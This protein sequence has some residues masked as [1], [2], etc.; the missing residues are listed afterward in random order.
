[1]KKIHRAAL[2]GMLI[3]CSTS[4]AQAACF[5]IQGKVHTTSLD[6]TTQLGT[7]ELNTEIGA[8]EGA[9]LGHITGANTSSIPVVTYLDHAVTFPGKAALFTH[10]DMGQLEPIP[11]DACTFKATEQLNIVGGA[12]KF[13][14]ASG[15]GTAVGTVNI[16]T[17]DNKFFISGQICTTP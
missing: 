17:G 12:G 3:A 10:N 15:S 1:M 14:G 16:C 2:A 8:L 6:Q 7:I 9:I 13:S 5:S 11:N 4:Y